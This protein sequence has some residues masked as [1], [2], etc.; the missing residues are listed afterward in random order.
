VALSCRPRNISGNDDQGPYFLNAAARISRRVSGGNDVRSPAMS[1]L[2][3]CDCSRK[4]SPALGQILQP[5]EFASSSTL[6]VPS[7]SA[8]RQGVGASEPACDHACDAR[9]TSS[10]SQNAPQSP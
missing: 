3:S 2:T 1:T 8:A 10:R 6:P 9:Q 7:T 4:Q 5:I